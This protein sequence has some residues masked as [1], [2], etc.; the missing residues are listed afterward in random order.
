MELKIEDALRRGI[1]AHKSGQLA[2]AD[3]F[4]TA[5]LTVQPAHPD[6]NHNLG[7]LAVGQGR[8]QDSL[9]FFKKALV[10]CPAIAQFWLSYADTLIKL[11]RIQ[12]AKKLFDKAL[13]A[14]IKDEPLNRLGVMLSNTQTKRNSPRAV[15]QVPAAHITLIAEKNNKRK[16]NEA[17]KLIEDLLIRFPKSEFL[18][19]IMAVSYAG[20]RNFSEAEKSCKKSLAINP[21]YPDAHN[22]LGIILYNKG[23]IAKSIHSYKKALEIKPNYAEACLNM[24]LALKEVGKL[25]KSIKCYEKV[26]ALNSSSFQA[27]NSLGNVFITKGDL[28]AGIES[29][30]S[31]ISIKA[32][33]VDAISNLGSA[34]R[35]KGDLNAAIDNYRKAIK[36]QPHYS[37]AYNNLGNALHEKGYLDDAIFHYQLA[38]KTNPNYAIA[39]GNMGNVLRDKKQ[40]KSALKSYEKAITLKPVHAEFYHNMGVVYNEIGDDQSALLKYTQCLKLKTDHIDTHLNIG[41]VLNNLGDHQAAKLSYEK[42]LS[43]DPDCATA[44]RNL[45]LLK[46]YK[47]PDEQFYQMKKLHGDQNT[48]DE[49]RSQL[50]FAIS[51]AYEDL[52]DFKKAFLYLEEANTL[53]QVNLA[54]NISHDQT[55]FSNLKSN[56]LNIK[57]TSL[58]LVEN[59]SS[60]TPVFIIGMPR[61]GTTLIE[62]IISSHS[63]VTGAGELPF[64][65]I[66]GGSIASG[67]TVASNKALLDFRD[68]YLSQLGKRSNGKLFVIDKMPLNF[69]Y[70]SLICASLPEAKIIHVKRVPA[71]TCWSNYRQ[72]F[73]DKTLGYSYNLN[74]IVSY[75]ALYSNLIHF[76]DKEYSSRIYHADYDRLTVE[77]EEETRRLINYLGLGW[78]EAC[79]SPQK[80]KESAKTA[81]NLQVR[82]KVYQGSSEKWR[83]FEPFLNGVFDDLKADE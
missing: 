79:L 45:S 12:E 30:K 31:A 23:E 81:S 41:V 61:S 80:N 38:I 9:P 59:K 18:Y 24:A 28:D 32:D 26:L 83:N 20:L 11:D 36:F 57:N 19:N 52:R 74:N 2:D 53:R 67:A 7:V 55:L 16:F 68:T 6:A 29:Y 13:N 33:Y 70:I 82:K 8:R 35:K 22:N 17:L 71:A 64:L 69:K 75:Y 48:K 15:V 56:S 40:F 77:Q 37:E 66:H 78:Q 51:K 5:V 72:Y 73:A 39:Y 54:Y 14:G 4:Y 44:H 27:H 65:E 3:R 10:A 47:E 46:T 62:K 60:L 42:V 34:L 63:N 21:D 50:S 58:K 1:Q 43:L 49:S 25:D 76:W